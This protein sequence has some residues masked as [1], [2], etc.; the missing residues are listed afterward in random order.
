MAPGAGA[1]ATAQRWREVRA[2]SGPSFGAVVD[3]ATVVFYQGSL[4]IAVV[5][6]ATV[7][8]ELV[9]DD[10]LDTWKKDL[11]PLDA[12]ILAIAK[13]PGGKRG[14]RFTEAI[15]LLAEEPFDDWPAAGPRTAMWCLQFLSKRGQGP[16]EHHYT[17]KQLSKLQVHDYGVEFHEAVMRIVELALT[18]D[19]VDGSNLAAL[20]VALRRAQIIEYYHMQ[21]LREGEHSLPGSSR[22]TMDEVTAFSGVRRQDDNLMLCPSLLDHARDEVGKVMEVNKAMRKHREEIRLQRGN[23]RDQPANAKKKKEGGDDG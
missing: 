20:E 15:S 8:V 23:N 19:Q 18:Y 17:W 7:A 1:A 12:R 13:L 14:R 2:A 5:E 9:A 4:G 21:R 16:L 22:L 3:P 6:G 10:V 11:R